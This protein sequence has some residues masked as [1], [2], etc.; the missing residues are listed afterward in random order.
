MY[1]VEDLRPRASPL[2]SLSI[3]EEGRLWQV[4]G[5]VEIER[6]TVEEGQGG[7]QTRGTLP[8]AGQGLGQIPSALACPS[9]LVTWGML[10][11]VDET[12]P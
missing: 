3:L 9:P 4:P 8:L 12:R 1:H 5:E 11:P 2:A 6:R 10:C 7:L